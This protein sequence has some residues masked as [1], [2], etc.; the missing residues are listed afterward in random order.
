MYGLYQSQIQV[1]A[2]TQV[3]IS[4]H[5]GISK[6][7][8][9]KADKYL[10]EIGWELIRKFVSTTKTADKYRSIM[11]M[12]FCELFACWQYNCFC[13]Y[14]E[15]KGYKQLRFVLSK[16]QIQKYDELIVDALKS[17]HNDDEFSHKY[18]IRILKRYSKSH[19]WLLEN[20]YQVA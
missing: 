9:K 10:D 20:G 19:Q 2:Q 15:E 5:G 3:L 16:E 13:Y 14:R 8:F 12:I 1:C 6:S 11:D 18:F 17:L 4:R 7:I